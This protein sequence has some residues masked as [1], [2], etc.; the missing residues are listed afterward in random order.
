MTINL[1]TDAGKTMV[2]QKEYSLVEATMGLPK[3]AFLSN[4]SSCLSNISGSVPVERH[5]FAPSKAQN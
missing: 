3:F 4:N 5:T 1:D 2:G